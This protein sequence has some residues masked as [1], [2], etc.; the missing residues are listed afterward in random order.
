MSEQSQIPGWIWL[1]TGVVTGLF[2][3]FL[4]YLA[5]IQPTAEQLNELNSPFGPNAGSGQ[6]A[7]R[8]EFYDQLPAEKLVSPGDEPSHNQQTNALRPSSRQ[9]TKTD[10]PSRYIIQTGSFQRTQEAEQ[11]KVK[12]LLMGLD[13]TVEKVNLKQKGT[14]HRVLVGPLQKKYVH[15]FLS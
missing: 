11:H 10:I 4:Y 7:P 15:T 12:L 9:A 14:W 8:F 2:L 1:F 6:S 13:V 3:A 5:S